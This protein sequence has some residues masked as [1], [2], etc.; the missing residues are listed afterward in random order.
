MVIFLTANGYMSIRK[1]TISAYVLFAVTSAG[2]QSNKNKQIS[3]WLADYLKYSINKKWI[4]N[5]DIQ[6]RNF[7]SQTVLGLF[8]IRSG[9]HYYFSKQWSTAIGGA[10]FH[11]QQNITDNKKIV[12]DEL[13]LWEE[14]KHEWKLGKWQIVNQFRTEQRHW[15]KQEGTAFRFRY[16]LAIDLLLAEKWKGMAGNELMWQSSR[17]RE[18]WD[19]YRLWIGGEY[20]FNSRNQ[21]QLLL[22]N[23]WQFNSHTSQPVVRINFIQS[24]NAAL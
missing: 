24:I 18:N 2:A 22:M 21:V 20:A 6:A 11:Q 4:V 1:L 14:L 13:R 12:T 10:W 8:A 17:I 15:A 9:V 7:T 19:Q 3:W 5:T 23:W 16:R